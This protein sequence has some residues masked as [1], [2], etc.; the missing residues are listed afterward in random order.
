[1]PDSA[2]GGIT[3]FYNEEGNVG[4]GMDTRAVYVFSHGRKLRLA[5]NTF[6]PTAYLKLVN[7]ENEIF[8]YYSTDGKRW[9]K[10]DKSLEVSGYNHNVFNGFLSLRA[11][12]FAIGK[13]EVRFSHFVYQGF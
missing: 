1:V 5:K 8:L 4:V 10:L 13:G 11:G 9:I 2:T 7:R 12:L 3:L 6:G